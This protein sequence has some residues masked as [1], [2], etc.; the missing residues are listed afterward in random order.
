VNNKIDDFE[1]IEKTIIVG[2]ANVVS[3]LRCPSCGAPLVVTFTE[4]SD[5][6]SLGIKCKKFCYRTNIDGLNE[7]PPWVKFLGN[8][9]ET[10]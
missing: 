7:V 8:R 10:K 4:S 2:E 5:K 6:R 3:S 9:F 1:E